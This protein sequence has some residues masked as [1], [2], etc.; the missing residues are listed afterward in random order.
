MP[1]KSGDALCF[2]PFLFELSPPPQRGLLLSLDFVHQVFVGSMASQAILLALAHGPLS[3]SESVNSLG[4]QGLVY[5]GVRL[6]SSLK[7]NTVRP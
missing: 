4:C 1:R 7:F 6:R 5:R 2:K 3:H